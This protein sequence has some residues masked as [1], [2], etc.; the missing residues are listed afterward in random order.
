MRSGEESVILGNGG[1]P[2]GLW[3]EIEFDC[4][5]ISVSPGD[6]ILLYSDGVTECVSVCGQAFGEERLL[7]YLREEQSSSLDEL[8]TR[9]LTEITAW[10]GNSEFTDDVSLLAIEIT[11]DGILYRD[12]ESIPETQSP[13]TRRRSD[14]I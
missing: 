6:R 12:E 3:P 13:Y 5:D 1:M 4:F 14:A 9:L 11:E 7:T 10:R 8:L 2:V